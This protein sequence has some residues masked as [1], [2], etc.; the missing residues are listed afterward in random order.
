[1]SDHIT[2]AIPGDIDTLTGGYV[3]DRRVLAQLRALGFDATHLQLPASFPFPTPEDIAET[4]R[5]LH[6]CRP[7]PMLIDGLAYGALPCDLLAG[8][9]GP[10]VA[11]CHPPLGLETGLSVRQAA[12]LIRSERAALAA[13][14]RVIVTSATTGGLLAHDFDVPSD[15]ITVAEPGTDPAERAAGSGRSAADGPL[16][17]AAGSIIPRKGFDVLIAAL[18]SIKEQPWHLLLVGSQSRAP[19]TAAALLAQIA[20]A[21]LGARIAMK[22]ELSLLQMAQAYANADVFV[23]PSRYEGFGM[24]LAEAMARGLPIVA[25][26]GGAAAQTVPDAAALKVPPGDAAALAE[27]LLRIIADTALRARLGD[28]SWTAGQDL[29]RWSRTAE[30][31]AAVLRA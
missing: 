9:P 11:L 18:E 12:G 16:L 20:E 19:E 15:I 29:Q 21:G 5:L 26:T 27:A 7:G 3:Y 13:A 24:V 1:M 6:A 22:G 14:H 2:F 30:I 8:L 31:I 23:L 25:S 28:A 17:M 10:V 4:A